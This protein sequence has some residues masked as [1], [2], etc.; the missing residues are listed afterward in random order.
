MAGGRPSIVTPVQRELIVSFAKEGL[1]AKK[2]K[3]LAHDDLKHLSLQTIYSVIFKADLIDVQHSEVVRKGRENGKSKASMIK[4]LL[5]KY[6]NWLDSAIA[7]EAGVKSHDTVRRIRARMRSVRTI[8]GD[9]SVLA[10]VQRQQTL[11]E[12]KEK[13]HRALR[14]LMLWQQRKL[15]AEQSV[16]PMRTCLGCGRKWFESELF[17]Y[18]HK[19]S[20]SGVRYPGSFDKFCFREKRRLSKKGMVESEIAESL[21]KPWLCAEMTWDEMMLLLDTEYSIG[22]SP[23][24]KCTVCGM[25]WDHEQFFHSVCFQGFAFVFNVCK[26]CPM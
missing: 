5:K 11:R 8:N 9:Y 13:K 19:D 6:P 18:Y 21:Q 22:Y 14:S 2:I 20:R 25:K 15:E 12:T 16:L 17:F 24:V 10:K 7:R 4:K 1:K 26:Q 23:P 3:S